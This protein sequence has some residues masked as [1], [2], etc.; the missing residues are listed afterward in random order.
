MLHFWMICLFAVL[1]VGEALDVPLAAMLV[2]EDAWR[3]DATPWLVAAG[4][5]AAMAALAGLTVLLI[6][7]EGRLLDRT[8]RH[9]HIRRAHL[10]ADLGQGA[11]V[12]LHVVGVIGF[13]WLHAI[14][15]GF[16]ATIGVGNPVLVDE[17][18]A[19]A[20]ALAVF[21]AGWWAL[22]GIDRRCREAALLGALDA[23]REPGLINLPT[24]R[25]F[26][27]SHIRHQM[28]M[29]FAPMALIIGW[30][31]CADWL[32]ALAEG[33]GALPGGLGRSLA[34]ALA[35]ENVREWARAALHF[36]GVAAIL[37]GAP[38]LLRLIW[39]TAPM[40]AG[41]LRERLEEICAGAKVRVR[42]ILIWRTHG[43]MI[44]GAVVGLVPWLRYILLTD[45]LL[46]SLTR[47][48][49]EAVMAH[50]VA[51]ARHRHMPWLAAVLLTVIGAAGL[52]VSL[53]LSGLA[54]IPWFEHLL[55]PATAAGGVSE[56]VQVA[57]DAVMGGVCLIAGLVA[58][59]WA[60]RRFEWQADA[61]AVQ[62]LS[63]VAPPPAPLASAPSDVPSP[64]D[65]PLPP[66][67]ASMTP[68]AVGAMAGALGAVASLNGIPRR[69]R[70]WR[71]GSIATRQAKLR[72][73]TG[74]P[75]AATPIDRTVR[76]I[77]AIAAAGVVVVVGLLIW[78]G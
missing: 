48:Q 65:L 35:S 17:L 1:F 16:E 60:S 44:N 20:P 45:A 69:K 77:K 75:I 52:V 19:V 29:T 50:E 27:M 76:R 49:V 12:G 31:E 61:F 33:G 62:C 5:I 43:S 39:E 53:V 63:L 66:G 54:M 14:R 3:A 10:L 78:L 18:L 56:A 70:S 58:F 6:L 34:A 38:L 11:A 23:G 68:A 40:P 41:P 21:V 2:G 32:L 7:R 37:V 13:G 74:L 24:R 46:D 26:V 8:G 47:T 28:L 15:A 22:Y 36:G 57:L 42:N 67:A 73:L 71:H 9:R 51:H 64:P 25:Q 4:Y 30:A 59:G 55:T 72:A